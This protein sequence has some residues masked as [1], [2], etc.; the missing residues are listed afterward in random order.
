MANFGYPGRWKQLIVGRGAEYKI[1]AL[2][3]RV[4]AKLS[5]QH[6]IRLS[7]FKPELDIDLTD[8]LI[9][10]ETKDWIMFMQ[11]QIRSRLKGPI[12]LGKLDSYGTIRS[13]AAEAAKSNVP[14]VLFVL[15]DENRYD[16]Y[17]T[18]K[19]R[20]FLAKRSS[21]PSPALSAQSVE[22]VFTSFILNICR[23]TSVDKAREAISTTNPS[24]RLN[25]DSFRSR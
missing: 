4:S 1:L 16:F 2:L 22:A 17:E 12:Q 10:V 6:G 5:L 20:R 11:V 21:V 14:V 8:L 15:G 23:C 18:R 25:Q 19:L 3:S 24:F 9:R 13:W 7:V